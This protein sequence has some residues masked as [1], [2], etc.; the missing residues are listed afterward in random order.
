MQ[1]RWYGRRHAHEHNNALQIFPMMDCFDCWSGF[2]MGSDII[3]CE[4]K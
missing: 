4:S 2:L 1:V 3:E